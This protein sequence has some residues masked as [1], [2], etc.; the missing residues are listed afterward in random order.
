MTR[1]LMVLVALVA[2]ACAATAA[3]QA[4]PALSLTADI[5]HAGR[6]SLDVTGPPGATVT[7]SALVGPEEQPLGTVT[8]AA[9]GTGRLAHA[10]TWVC[11]P[12]RRAFR[13]TTGATTV[14][15]AVHTPGCGHRYAIDVGPRHPRAHR[16]ATVT[17]TDRWRLGA[18]SAP[19]C[20]HGPAGA[21]RCGTIDL[22]DGTARGAWRFHPKAAGRW[23][24]TV[25]RPGAHRWH[26]TRYVRPRT[27]RVSLLATGDSMIQIIDGF[28][29]QRL[30]SSKVAVRSDARISTGITKPSLLD[31]PAHARTQVHRL[32]PDVT[33]MFLGANDGFGLDGAACCG[34]AWQVAYAHRASGMMRTYARRGLG[35][36][37]WLLL[38]APRRADFARVYRAV[39]KALLRA[40]DRHPGVVRIVDLRRTFTPD[41]RFHQSIRW[42]GRSVSVRQSDGTHLNV[43]GARI[44]ASIII[45]AMRR[46]G[47]V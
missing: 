26:T 36:V 16:P 17:L 38:P 21:R 41:D 3:A 25:H 8:L 34:H 35:T 27:G 32:H 22:P 45:R 19:V 29:K 7:L 18:I 11:S 23:R 15:T 37:Y 47:V 12:R 4:P 20:A 9:D 42:H 14:D 10:A 28:L 33:V 13:A 5:A 6:I 2:A 31:W 30:Q 43:A 44:A 1:V 39:D 24:V 40:A 46:D